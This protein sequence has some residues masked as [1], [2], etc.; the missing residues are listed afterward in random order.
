MIRIREEEKRA[1]VDRLER[2]AVC[3]EDWIKD[4]GWYARQRIETLRT[5]L[6]AIRILPDL[7]DAFVALLNVKDLP[8]LA[9]HI[10][11]RFTIMQALRELREQE[12]KES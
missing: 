2:A 12:K 8:P 1:L 6:W 4:A 10:L 9:I 3:L 7:L 5:A 11:E